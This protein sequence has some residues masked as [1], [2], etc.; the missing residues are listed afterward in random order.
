M[1]TSD[2]SKKSVRSLSNKNNKIN[3]TYMINKNNNNNINR[4]KKI[5]NSNSMMILIKKL[6][7]NDIYFNNINILNYFIYSIK[8]LRGLGL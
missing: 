8:L 7:F 2:K 3:N 6:K 1:K 4:D 5:K